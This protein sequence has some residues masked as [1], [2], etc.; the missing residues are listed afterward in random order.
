M[1]WLM[2]GL[3]AGGGERVGTLPRKVRRPKLVVVNLY[4]I[5]IPNLG[6]FNFGNC[7]RAHPPPVGSPT[8]HTRSAC[9]RRLS[10]RG[11][12]DLV[13]SWQGEAVHRASPFLA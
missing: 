12:P 10:L 4:L 9:D 8:Q 7:L 1:Y 6:R 13:G 11:L 2:D 5:F 3:L